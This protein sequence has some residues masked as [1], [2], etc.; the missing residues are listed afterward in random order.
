MRDVSEYRIVGVLWYKGKSYNI[1][2]DFILFGKPDK[3]D[4]NAEMSSLGFKTYA[5]DGTVTADITL[6]KRFESK[7][8]MTLKEFRTFIKGLRQVPSAKGYSAYFY[9]MALRPDRCYGFIDFSIC[10]PANVDFDELHAFVQA[11]G[12]RL[13]QRV[14]GH[15]RIDLGIAGDCVPDE[16]WA[17]EIL[18]AIEHTAYYK[19]GGMRSGELCP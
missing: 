8:Y 3:S 15:N 4:I 9:A 13:V 7:S 18:G 5:P 16:S 1:D 11:F 17:A 12:Y 6:I 10:V 19:R 2:H 14:L